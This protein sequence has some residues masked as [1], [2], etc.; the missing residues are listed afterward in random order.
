MR[1][2]LRANKAG[3]ASWPISRVLCRRGCRRDGHSSGTPVARRLEQPTR[4]AM[5]KR[6]PKRGGR[7]SM[8]SLF[9]FAPGG[10]CPAASVT[11]RAVRSYRTLSPLLYFGLPRFAL[12]ETP[13]V[14]T[15]IKRFAFCG[16]FPRVAPA[17]RYPAPCF[18]GARTFL[19]LSALQPRTATTRV[20]SSGHPANWHIGIGGFP[21]RT[22]TP[23]RE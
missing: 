23:Q 14:M 8:P 1:A 17:G 4:T 16:T 10:V 19:H 2:V 9:G 15:R 18:R 12:L 6:I 7:A 11:S 3:N 13:T 20:P 5:R 22:S 21:A